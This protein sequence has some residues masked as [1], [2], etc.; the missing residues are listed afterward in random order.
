MK[1]ENSRLETGAGRSPRW[2]KNIDALRR[3]APDVARRV[4]ESTPARIDLRPTRGNLPTAVHR[5]EFLHSPFH[6]GLEV[7]TLL[8][9]VQGSS[10]AERSSSALAASCGDQPGQDGPEK[11]VAGVE[12]DSSDVL[13]IYGLGLGYHAR[14]LLDRTRRRLLVLEP[15]PA[16][17]AGLFERI[18]YAPLFASKRLDMVTRVDDLIS[19]LESAMIIGARIDWVVLAGYRRTY[20]DLLHEAERAVRVWH[21]LHRRQ[22]DDP[23][24]HASATLIRTLENAAHL[25]RS[26]CA[27]FPITGKRGS[28]AVIV[29]GPST[30]DVMN[31]LR[32]FQDRFSLIRIEG[33]KIHMAPDP[34]SGSGEGFPGPVVCQAVESDPIPPA[35]KSAV[36]IAAHND[37]GA[38]MG[39]LLS[40]EYESPPFGLSCELDAIF[41]CGRWFEETYV[42]GEEDS[43]TWEA[44][45][46]FLRSLH[47]ESGLPP[48]CRL[49]EPTEFAEMAR[50]WPQVEEARLVSDEARRGEAVREGLD[51]LS[52][53]LDREKSE[54]LRFMGEVQS[55]YGTW[56]VLRSY[57]RTT[58]S[59]VSG[60]DKALH[61]ENFVSDLCTRLARSRLTAS[62]GKKLIL[63]VVR[64]PRRRA[65]EPRGIEMKVALTDAFLTSLV[66][67]LPRISMLAEQVLFHAELDLRSLR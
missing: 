21:S 62:L 36:Y 60:A 16:L 3:V 27:N 19:A 30:G 12:V 40:P 42:L 9:G 7:N 53:A 59:V 51:R 43:P 34:M 6:P 38:W 54:M 2:R 28:R 11:A 50:S 10:E 14:E 61:L 45:R 65:I 56:T 48:G 47:P 15:D 66:V 57:L 4:E 44:D 55:I 26:P 24:I 49:V 46:A 32:E 29:R 25:W 63:E 1:L 33:G 35:Q 31:W 39:R 17:L 23:L 5:G 67:D 20:L 18:D 52:R 22:V 64:P 8:Q 41:L 58:E 13:I 37:L